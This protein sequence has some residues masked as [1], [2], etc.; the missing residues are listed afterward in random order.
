MCFN[1]LLIKNLLE[2]A[3]RVDTLG[4]TLVKERNEDLMEE[5]RKT[6]AFEGPNE[7]S[8]QQKT[9]CYHSNCTLLMRPL[10]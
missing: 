5:I 10:G 8:R 6:V 3:E 7:T 2:L 9:L 4:N 1:A